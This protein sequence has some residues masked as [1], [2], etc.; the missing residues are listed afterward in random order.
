MGNHEEKHLRWRMH[1][2]RRAT[3]PSYRNPMRPLEPLQAAQNRA[4][5]AADIAWM[6]ALP[7]L[8]ELEDWV[9]VH[10]GLLPGL[11]PAAQSPANLLRLRWLNSN[12]KHLPLMP[13]DP[14]QPPGSH[15]WMA[16]YDGQ[17]HVVYGHAAHSLTTPRVDRNPLG[18][19]CW[20]IDTGATYGGRLT[21]LVLE[22][23]QVI[24]VQAARVYRQSTF[25][26]PS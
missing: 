20:G 3:D 22:T 13:E 24:Q 7:P 25:P 26:I 8:L 5:S 11:P 1:E 18:A 23:R 19:E 10:G 2:E 16:V 4:L 15:P 21:A 6:A 12:G 9:V 17:R 14:R